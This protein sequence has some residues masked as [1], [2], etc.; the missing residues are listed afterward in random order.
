MG[1]PHSSMTWTIDPGQEI[2]L[3]TQAPVYLPALLT[4]PT[5]AQNCNQHGDNEQS[6]I[7][8]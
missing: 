6:L 5:G 3:V 2:L 1:I 7:H 8:K 4:A